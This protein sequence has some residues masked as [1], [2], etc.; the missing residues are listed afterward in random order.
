MTLQKFIRRVEIGV[1]TVKIYWNLDREYYEREL[2]I[3][4][5]P[6]VTRTIKLVIT[7]EEEYSQYHLNL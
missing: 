4:V 1:D 3:K 7:R 5:N 6:S 2:K